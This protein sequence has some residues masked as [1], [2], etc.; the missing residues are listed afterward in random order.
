[1][2]A[3]SATPISWDPASAQRSLAAAQSWARDKLVVI[4]AY[5]K[6]QYWQSILEI[7]RI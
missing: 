1:M 2:P 4:V 3:E 7:Y 5:D 6:S